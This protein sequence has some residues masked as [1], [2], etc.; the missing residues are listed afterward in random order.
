MIVDELELARGYELAT[1]LTH[2]EPSTLVGY[3]HVRVFRQ[4]V[5]QGGQTGETCWD[6]TMNSCPELPS[7]TE[8]PDPLPALGG[9]DRLPLSQGGKP[10]AEGVAPPRGAPGRMIKKSAS[11]EV[12][13]LTHAIRSRSSG[14]R[15]GVNRSAR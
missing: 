14:F 10:L 13:C 11:A 3:D 7:V 6:T 4:V 8:F 2:L 5:V 9:E 1:K 12:F 15:T